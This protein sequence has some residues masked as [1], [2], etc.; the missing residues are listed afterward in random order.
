VDYMSLLM[1]DMNNGSRVAEGAGFDLRG[2]ADTVEP[3]T[4]PLSAAFASVQAA[5]ILR[6]HSHTM[7]LLPGSSAKGYPP[8]Q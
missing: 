2:S 6:V 3:G 4:G 5:R 1:C 8:R 7:D